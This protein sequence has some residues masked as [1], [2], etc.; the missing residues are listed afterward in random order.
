[1][2]CEFLIDVNLPRLF[3]IWNSSKYIHQF[4]LGD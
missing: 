1:M 4:D 3:S 2:D